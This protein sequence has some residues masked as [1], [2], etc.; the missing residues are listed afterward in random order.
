[1]LKKI[2]IVIL[3]FSFSGLTQHCLNRS[4]EFEYKSTPFCSAQVHDTLVLRYLSSYV[5]VDVYG[6]KRVCLMRHFVI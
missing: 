1:M 3:S 2:A 4:S 5:M 6:V